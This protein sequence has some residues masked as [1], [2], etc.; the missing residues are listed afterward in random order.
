MSICS[1]LPPLIHTP[2]NDKH[3]RLPSKSTGSSISKSKRLSIPLPT[4]AA[5]AAEAELREVRE[6]LTA[7][8]AEER[9]DEEAVGEAEAWLAEWPAVRRELQARVDAGGEAAARAWAWRSCG[10]SRS[11]TA[12]E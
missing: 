10:R 2:D 4:A 3:H 1:H 5:E 11:P 7:L 9:D 8:E 12:G 6:R